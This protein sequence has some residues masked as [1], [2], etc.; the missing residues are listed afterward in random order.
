MSSIV[1][2]EIN[3]QSMLN[4]LNTHTDKVVPPISLQWSTDVQKADIGQ[5][6][7]RWCMT[8]QRRNFPIRVEA[9]R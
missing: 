4:L 7:P 3:A 2:A 8:S 6:S 5:K 9:Y 1:T